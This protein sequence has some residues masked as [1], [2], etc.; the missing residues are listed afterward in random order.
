MSELQPPDAGTDEVDG[1]PGLIEVH[2]VITDGQREQAF[3]RGLDITAFMIDPETKK[4][5]PIYELKVFSPAFLLNSILE[6]YATE[7]AYPALQLEDIWKSFVKDS[8]Y[9][10]DENKFMTRWY[11]LIQRKRFTINQTPPRP[12]MPISRAR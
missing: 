2:E 7:R 5:A 6:F 3:S 8:I 10:K 12:V 4:L 1:Q 9:E 11:E